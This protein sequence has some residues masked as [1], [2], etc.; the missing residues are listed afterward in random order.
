MGIAAAIEEDVS[1][2]ASSF[3]VG[4]HLGG[5]HS[6]RGLWRGVRG[7]GCRRSL[8]RETLDAYLTAPVD[9]HE[10]SHRHWIQPLSNQILNNL[11]CFFRAVRVLVRSIRGQRIKGVGHRDDSGQQRN[12][13]S[14]K[15]IRI[16]AAVK[17][18]GGQFDAW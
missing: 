14:L 12:L 5:W 3:E 2:G 4:N 7:L 1:L 15:A 13:I 16:S 18:F 10:R 8:Y 6:S 17:C 11:Q 9:C